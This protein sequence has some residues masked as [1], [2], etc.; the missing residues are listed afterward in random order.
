MSSTAARQG[1]RSATST[2]APSTARTFSG[3]FETRRTDLSPKYRMDGGGQLVA[4]QI[5]LEAQT[6]VGLH[7][8]GP[9]VLQFIG[10][11]LVQQADSAALLIFVDQPITFRPGL[12]S[13]QVRA[14]SKFKSVNRS[15]Q[16]WTIVAVADLVLSSI[17]AILPACRSFFDECGEA[18]GGVPRRHQL[19]QIDLLDRG[20]FR[21]NPFD[22]AMS[23]DAG[24][25]AQ[26]FRAFGR[27]MPIEI[28]ERGGFGIVGDLRHE[29]D[30]ECL[31]GAD[32]APGK[33]E[34]LGRRKSDAF[35]QQT[36]SG[37][38]EDADLNLRLA[39]FGIPSGKEQMSGAR[40]L[41][42]AAETLATDRHQDRNW[43]SK[44]LQDQPMEAR[45]HRRASIRQVFLDRG[46][47]AEMCA[48]RSR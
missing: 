35:G 38:R 19:G 16:R 7:G 43:R 34:V 31:F 30:P 14:A 8:V 46:T 13:F 24:G 18:F 42:T 32:R 10:A 20:K 2:P 11:E 17:S 12:A 45:E 1:T 26:R 25:E 48:G 47:K 4:P 21:R 23:G 29:A 5:R 3:L 9:V 40:E 28:T 37:R 39:E 15:S 36:G 22:R 27:Q 41:E 44:D 33:Q 6:L